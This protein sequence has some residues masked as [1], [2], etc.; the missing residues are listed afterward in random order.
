MY[1]IE[2]IEIHIFTL[3]LSTRSR[4]TFAD[5]TLSLVRHKP[6]TQPAFIDHMLSRFDHNLLK[7]NEE[8]IVLAM[9]MHQL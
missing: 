2:Y 4:T 7:I 6:F 5:H 1:I 9:C 3:K 8:K